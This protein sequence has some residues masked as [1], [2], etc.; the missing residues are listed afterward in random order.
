M[1]WPP[2]LIRKSWENTSALPSFFGMS[3]SSAARRRRKGL[4][5]HPPHPFT[6]RMEEHGTTS[7]A[8]LRANS[9][10]LKGSPFHHANIPLP[11]PLKPKRI[12]QPPPRSSPGTLPLLFPLCALF[13]ILPLFFPNKPWGD[14]CSCTLPSPNP[15][16]QYL[17][18]PLLDMRALQSQSSH[19]NQVSDLPLPRSLRTKK[20]R[21]P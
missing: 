5:E 7:S 13:S 10:S 19:E 6:T 4:N 9:S 17:L 12:T 8:S 2:A 1:S 18:A 20:K 11:Q 15:S 21:Q 14:G 3:H 16:C